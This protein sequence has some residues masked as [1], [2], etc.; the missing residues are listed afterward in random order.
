[1]SSMRVHT[2]FVYRK[3]Q[4]LGFCFLG[5]FFLMQ[6]LPYGT[7]LS[8]HMATAFLSG[9]KVPGEPGALEWRHK[10]QLVGMHEAS[11]TATSITNVPDNI[12]TY[13]LLLSSEHQSP[14]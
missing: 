12:C 4:G 5:F 8:K 6:I 7:Q 10:S 9:T 1:M 11:L 2:P 3:H 13:R 14:W